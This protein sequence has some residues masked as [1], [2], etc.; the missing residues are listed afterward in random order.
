MYLI[1]IKRYA[2][3]IYLKNDSNHPDVGCCYCGISDKLF[4]S[5]LVD[6]MGHVYG[7]L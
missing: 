6:A 4:T 5:S 1:E 7:Y 3:I 2:D